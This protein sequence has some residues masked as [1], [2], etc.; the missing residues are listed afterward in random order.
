M[1]EV[2]KAAWATPPSDTL[3]AVMAVR[4]STSLILAF[5]R[6]ESPRTGPNGPVVST[7]NNRAE[8]KRTFIL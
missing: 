8:Q 1:L 5:T 6:R 3:R 4:Q 7:A 2:G